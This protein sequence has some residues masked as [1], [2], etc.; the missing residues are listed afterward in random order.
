L[1]TAVAAL[2]Q[3]PGVPRQTIFDTFH[4]DGRPNP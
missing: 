4:A 3:S 2:G 1:L